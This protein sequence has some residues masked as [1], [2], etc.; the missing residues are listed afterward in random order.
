MLAL[1]WAGPAQADPLEAGGVI[2]KA[3]WC[4]RAMVYLDNEGH[5][6]PGV[7]AGALREHWVDTVIEELEAVGLV[8]RVPTMTYRYV[9]E[10]AEQMPVFLANGDSAALRFNLQECLEP[11]GLPAAEDAS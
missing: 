6:L 8:D 7:D 11:D 4:A 9:E 1:T 5:E 3:F 10:I 2:D